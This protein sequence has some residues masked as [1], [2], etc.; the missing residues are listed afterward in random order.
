MYTFWFSHV[1]FYIK[2][3]K[4]RLQSH[5]LMCNNISTVLNQ[6]QKIKKSTILLSFGI[7]LKHDLSC[8]CTVFKKNSPLHFPPLWKRFFP[9]LLMRDLTSLHIQ[10]LFLLFASFQIS[11]KSCTS[12]MYQN[13]PSG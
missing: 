1:N 11:V 5:G 12:N 2:K 7:R 9:S 13:T 3:I 4:T 10:I 8:F 6:N